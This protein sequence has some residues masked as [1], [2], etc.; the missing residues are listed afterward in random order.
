MRPGVPYGLRLHLQ[1]RRG[2]LAGVPAR[3]DG[4]NQL[5]VGER[6]AVPV[7]VGFQ[8]MGCFRLAGSD[9]EPQAR[10]IQLAQVGGR[11]H[12]SV[13]NDDHVVGAVAFLEGFHGRQDRLGF[14]LVPL[15]TR[16]FQ[17]EALPVDEQAHHDLGVHAPLL[18]IP[19]LSKLVFLLS[20][21]IQ[22]RHVVQDKRQ[23]PARQGVAE[24]RC[25]DLRPVVVPVGPLQSRLQGVAVA[26]SNAELFKDKPGS[27]DG[28]GCD[29]AGGDK[30]EEPFIT[31]CFF[32]PE[33]PVDATDRLQEQTRLLGDHNRLTR[34]LPRVGVQ[35]Q[36]LLARVQ[37]IVRDAKQRGKLAVAVSSTDMLQHDIAS[38]AALSDLHFDR[39]I[40]PWHL[41]NEHHEPTIPS[42]RGV[43]STKTKHNPTRKNTLKRSRNQTQLCN[44]G[45]RRP[46]VPLS[47]PAVFRFREPGLF[48]WRGRC[49]AFP[50]VHRV[51]GDP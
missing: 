17:G 40:T 28:S 11:E 13:R 39:T 21:E 49:G 47:W 36:R 50:V 19:H 23:V 48:W 8:I 1:V 26:R 46:P 32:K 16:D 43:S 27:P 6:V 30:L 2:I 38:I 44:S 15:P 14:R 25:G 7:E 24:T 20:L 51:V 18:R 31:Q 22:G 45:G 9:N 33:E 37:M 35:R 5:P 29:E 4:V 12:A 42:P 34:H 3:G 41:A 10:L